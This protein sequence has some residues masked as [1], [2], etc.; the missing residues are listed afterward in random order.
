M[1]DGSSQR[2]CHESKAARNSACGKPLSP[3]RGAGPR[4]KV[5]IQEGKSPTA[6]PWGATAHRRAR[7]PQFGLARGARRKEQA[8][9]RCRARRPRC[10]KKHGGEF[11]GG[12]HPCTMATHGAALGP[13]VAE[14]R[15]GAARRPP[16]RHCAAA[17]GRR[18]RRARPLRRHSPVPQGPFPCSPPR[19]SPS[20]PSLAPRTRARQQ[21]GR[22]E[23]RAGARVRSQGCRGGQGNGTFLCKP[24]L[25]RGPWRARLRASGAPSA[26][27]AGA[28][29]APGA[30]SPCTSPTAPAPPA[31]RVAAMPRSRSLRSARG[32]AAT[33]AQ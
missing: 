8:G 29:C 7:A 10:N 20:A 1:G 26:P 19:P 4:Q 16:P 5:C 32:A 23:P 13:P 22:G 17:E 2:P 31:P 21:G 18:A 11:S 3:E 30:A 27:G 25:A 24:R 14:W 28:A 12:A 9:Q 6:L 15:R 33:R